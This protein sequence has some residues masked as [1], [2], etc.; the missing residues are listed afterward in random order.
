MKVPLLDTTRSYKVLKEELEAAALRVLRSGRY[1]MGP[2]VEAFEAAC[3]KA[4]GSPHALG[5]TSGT[6]AL[7]LALMALGVGP[8]DEVVVPTYT[9][10]ATASSVARLGA[11]PVFVDSCARCMNLDVTRVTRTKKTRAI[12]PVHL[13]GQACE[14]SPLL[15]LGVPVIEDAC[16]AIGATHGGKPVGSLGDFGA[17]SFFPSKN[18]GAFGDAGLLTVRDAAMAEACRALRVHGEK[19]RYDHQLL[20]ANFRIDALQAALLA[21][22]LPHLGAA[23]EARRRNAARYNQLF[24]EAGVGAPLGDG[25]VCSETC[26][27]AASG[28]APLYFPAAVRETHVYN[29]YVV[30][31]PGKREALKAHLAQAGVD[32][33]VY[34]PV[35]LH[36]QKAFAGLGHGVGAFPVAE[37]LAQETLA[38]PI[39]SELEA[40]ELE[41]VAEQVIGF[42]RKG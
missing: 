21:V 9:F 40:K 42:F 33:A 22:K 17:F 32:T 7:V 4:I 2:E 10:F 20:G 3:Q 35:P 38:L 24:A 12:I 36:L 28:Q 15:S 31:V 41:Y 8:G 14:L 19:Q 25:P 23:Q 13:F 34:Y 16:Q 18:L 29:Q 37:K 1:I 39:Y 6:D 11:T 26:K 5:V 27:R 30:R